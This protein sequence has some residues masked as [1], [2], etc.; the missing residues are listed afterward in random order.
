MGDPRADVSST[1]AGQK[2]AKPDFDWDLVGAEVREKVSR[3]ALKTLKN[4]GLYG[5]TMVSAI[6]GMVWITGLTLTASMDALK[7]LCALGV[8]GMLMLVA[9]A[10]MFMAKES[11]NVATKL[12]AGQHGSAQPGTGAEVQGTLGP[13]PEADGSAID[14]GCDHRRALGVRG[15]DQGDGSR[16]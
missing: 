4:S 14:G 10:A 2:T 6:V 15:A 12:E 16:R 9:L 7:A 5:L 1:Q 8:S 3:V 13:A 11:S